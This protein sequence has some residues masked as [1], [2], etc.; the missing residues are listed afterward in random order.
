[1]SSEQV[2]EIFQR[3][4]KTDYALNATERINAQWGDSEFVCFAKQLIEPNFESESVQF[5]IE[6]QLRQEFVKF[7]HGDDE[8]DEGVF[9]ESDIS[10]MFALQYI[11]TL[12]ATMDG[13]Q[14]FARTDKVKSYI[15]GYN[16]S[17]PQAEQLKIRLINIVRFIESM[18]IV[19]SSR[20][21]KKANLFSLIAELDKV[22]LGLVDAVTLREKLEALDIK[23]TYNEIG[24]NEATEELTAEEQTYFSFAREAVNQKAARELRGKFLSKMIRGAMVK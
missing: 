13:Q 10:R 16:E 8:D 2:R 22:E 21:Y 24:I 23:A 17:F 1:V 12:V 5:K 20:W 4:N 14:Y 7:F 18:A 19:R 11:M 3:I 15:E 6:E 9:S